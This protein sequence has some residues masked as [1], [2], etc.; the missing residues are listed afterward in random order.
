MMKLNQYLAKDNTQFNTEED[1]IKYESE[2]DFNNA[3][4]SEEELYLIFFERTFSCGGYR[5]Q[6]KTWVSDINTKSELLKFLQNKNENCIE[7][8]NGLGL[9]KKSKIINYIDAGSDYYYKIIVVRMR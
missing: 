1:C 2:L 7:D 5:T 4:K 6:I 8:I 3:L 9:Y